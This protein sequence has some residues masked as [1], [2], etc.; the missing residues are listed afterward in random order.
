MTIKRE[1][2]GGVDTEDS[3]ADGDDDEEVC[4][5]W[6]NISYILMTLGRRTST[7]VD[8]LLFLFFLFSQ[9]AIGLGGWR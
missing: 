3:G 8:F 2:E 6:P 5:R 9:K 1:E 4:L 7:A